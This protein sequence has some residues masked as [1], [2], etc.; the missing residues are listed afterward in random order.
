MCFWS[1]ATRS[2]VP[3]NNTNYFVI[4]ETENKLLLVNKQL[5]EW[6]RF[7]IIGTYTK[8]E[9]IN[10]IK[11]GQFFMTVYQMQIDILR[12]ENKKL[13]EERELYISYKTQYDKQELEHQAF[14][15]E[16]KA[17]A[18]RIIMT[19]KQENEEVK[20][21]LD[22]VKTAKSIEVEKIVERP[23]PHIVER[24]KPVY[25]E[26]EFK[27]TKKKLQENVILEVD[28][29]ISIAK[30]NADR[31]RSYPRHLLE[32]RV[33]EAIEKSCILNKNKE[34]Y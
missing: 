15:R 5:S 1:G 28:R 11:S 25:I 18:N 33:L 23:V 27:V 24:D 2:I 13:K 30:T 34:N 19:L 20:E 22:Q 14:I 7:S 12:E 4:L 32:K 21:E 9:F 31:E 3:P 29:Y 6:S 26:K 10:R 17:Q 16:T 8:E